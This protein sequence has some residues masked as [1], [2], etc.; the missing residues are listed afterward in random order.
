MKIKFLLILLLLTQLALASSKDIKIS[1]EP[2]DIVEPD[3]TFTLK[4][5]IENPTTSPI[6][7]IKIKVEEDTPFIIE[8]NEIKISELEPN[9]TKTTYFNIEVE[10]TEANTYD[11]EI[12]YKSKI[13]PNFCSI[14][15]NN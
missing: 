11:L 8:N 1:I 15:T 2:I 14:C 3:S 12:K 6:E 5:N 4:I 13:R 9:E 10:D 7:D